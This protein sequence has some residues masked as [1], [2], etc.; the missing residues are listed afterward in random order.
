MV[1]SYPSQNQLSLDL[2]SSIAYAML[3]TSVGLEMF[4]LSKGRVPLKM[5]TID[6]IRRQPP[7]SWSEVSGCVMT[8]TRLFLHSVYYIPPVLKDTI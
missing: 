2:A 7:F 6:K 4:P 1:L 3:V 8:H 5:T